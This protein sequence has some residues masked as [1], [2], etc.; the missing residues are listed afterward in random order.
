VI[1]RKSVE[2]DGRKWRIAVKDE[3]FDDDG[4]SVLGTCDHNNRTIEI[5]KGDD[6]VMRD[7]LLHE[8]AHA[9]MPEASERDVLDCERGLYALR[10][11]N[12]AIW[13]WIFDR[14]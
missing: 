12:Q 5:K 10:R 9:I 13:S 14:E 8:L 7:T 1:P 6:G 2:I 11:A 3:V 4:R